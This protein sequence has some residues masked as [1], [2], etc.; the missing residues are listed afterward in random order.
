MS[1]D[2]CKRK[3]EIRK[4]L[5]AI[6][7]SHKLGQETSMNAKISEEKAQE[8]HV[9]IRRTSPTKSTLTMK[10]KKINLTVEKP[11]RHTLTK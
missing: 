3:G 11:D 9:Y 7:P 2:E 10:R 8:Q 1:T 4:P 5:L 6:N